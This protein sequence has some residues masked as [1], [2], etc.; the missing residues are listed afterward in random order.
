MPEKM[1]PDICCNSKAERER[2]IKFC[3][4][5]IQIGVSY[6]GKAG[7]PIYRSNLI[8]NGFIK[9]SV[10]LANGFIILMDAQNLLCAAPIIRM[11]ID[12]LLRVN[13]INFLIDPNDIFVR[14]I[15]GEKFDR[16]RDDEGRLLKD[17]ILRKHAKKEFPWIDEIYGNTSAFIHFS[18]K[19]IFS[20]ICQLD[21]KNQIAYSIIG[22]QSHHVNDK[23]INLYY[24]TMNKISQCIL[25]KMSA[26]KENEW[27]EPEIGK[28]IINK[29]I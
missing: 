25:E 20:P 27:N 16:I 9:R 23:F 21:K 22:N 18:D 28:L 13:Y 15:S 8:L 4:D 14:L 5:A 29:R 24:S 7:G 3:D 1:P 10:D 12:T 19:H 26:M 11:Q 2:L 17:F 6:S